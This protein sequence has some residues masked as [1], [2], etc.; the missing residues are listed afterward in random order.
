[1]VIVIVCLSLETTSNIL[2]L[3]HHGYTKFNLWNFEFN[4]ILK[5]TLRN[6]T[7]DVITRTYHKIVLDKL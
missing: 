4:K 5:A 7:I 2:E 3:E 6:S 1:M